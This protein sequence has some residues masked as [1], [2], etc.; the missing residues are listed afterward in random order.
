M[1]SIFTFLRVVEMRRGA[2]ALSSFSFLFPLLSHSLLSS[3]MTSIS[4]RLIRELEHLC[5]PINNKLSLESLRDKLEEARSTS[6]SFLATSLFF[7]E[8]C[9]HQNVTEDMIKLVLEIS[10]FAAYLCTNKYHGRDVDLSGVEFEELES[11]EHLNRPTY[12]LMSD[13]SYA[14][15]M[16]CANPHCPP[17]VISVLAKNNPS[18]VGHFCLLRGGCKPGRDYDPVMG[19][20]IHYYLSR[21]MTLDLDVVKCLVEEC[22]SCLD[23][24]GASNPEKYHPIHALME[25]TS[26][27][28]RID[29]L[30]YLLSVNSDCVTMKDQ[31]S[32]L[33]IHMAL[34]NRQ[35]QIEVV[36]LLIRLWPDSIFHRDNKYHF[37]LHKLLGTPRENNERWIGIL[38]L[39][40]ETYP[41][42]LHIPSPLDGAYPLHLAANYQSISF[43][44]VL[45]DTYPESVTKMDRELRLPFHIACEHGTFQTVQYLYELNPACINAMDYQELWPIHLASARNHDPELEVLRFLVRN[46]KR[47]ISAKPVR[48]ENTI[49]SHPD[50]PLHYAAEKEGSLAAIQYLFNAYPEALNI[51]ATRFNPRIARPSSYHVEFLT[52]IKLARRSGHTEAVEFFQSQLETLSMYRAQTSPLLCAVQEKAALGI[53]KLLANECKNYKSIC[54]ENNNTPLHHACILGRV[55]IINYLLEK[56]PMHGNGQNDDVK[57]PM[58]LLLETSNCEDRDSL[59]YIEAVWHLLVANPQSIKFIGPLLDCD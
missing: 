18:A 44:K 26:A 22:S 24:T 7:H 47:G 45:T 39:L 34:E 5:S 37:P 1:S 31:E 12:D 59:D 27:E 58:D 20:P 56:W 16:A 33:P 41:E 53:V 52:P 49:V 42:I 2:A 48:T 32:K 50:T 40:V 28:M 54:D 6:E 11:N 23:D 46:D 17:Q 3:R 30:E 21:T 43:V 15:H 14:I 29:V 8:L 51:E 35:M 4:N 10:P 25:N 55:D 36:E 57:L 9:S 38:K 19:L 13:R